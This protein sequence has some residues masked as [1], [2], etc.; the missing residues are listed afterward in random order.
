M[1]SVRLRTVRLYD[2]AVPLSGN[3]MLIQTLQTNN[4]AGSLWGDSREIT[5]SGA[6]IP[7]AQ[8]RSPK[9]VSFP[10]YGEGDGEQKGAHYKEAPF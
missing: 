1:S 10:N 8:Q 2:V 3:G 5:Q 6:L 9:K 7:P 4:N